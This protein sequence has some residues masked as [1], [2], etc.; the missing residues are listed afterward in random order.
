[1]ELARLKCKVRQAPPVNV[2]EL[3]IAADFSNAYAPSGLEH[4][5]I[6]LADMID[7]DRRDPN[8]VYNF[9]NAPQQTPVVKIP[10]QE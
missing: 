1:M 8:K 2:A 6:P 7:P 5:K 4:I 10:R 9:L 3:I